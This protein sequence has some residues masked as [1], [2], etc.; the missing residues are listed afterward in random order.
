MKLV[1]SADE[2]AVE[3]LLEEIRAKI[4]EASAGA[5]QDAAKVAVAEGD[6][7]ISASGLTLR[8]QRTVGSKFYPNEGGDPASLVFFTWSFAQIFERGAT[9]S[10]SPL[11]WLP[12]GNKAGVKRPRKYGRKLVSVNIPGKPP[13][14]FDAADR[15][16]GPLFFGVSSVSIKKRLDLR[17]IFRAA[18]ERV[19]EFYEQRMKG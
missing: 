4:Y 10:G 14:L 11:L 7:N 1:F 17:R 2:S 18:A 16:R 8:K 6:A 5:V 19:R 3:T 12:I 9:I 13:L 15:S